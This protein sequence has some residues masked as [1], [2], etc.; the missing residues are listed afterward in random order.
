MGFPLL[1][2]LLFYLFRYTAPPP[3]RAFT[4]QS[5][6]LRLKPAPATIILHLLN[7]IVTPIHHIRT[8]AMVYGSCLYKMNILL[9]DRL[10]SDGLRR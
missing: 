9:A 6:H 2:L 7:I 1:C 8:P 10:W 3:A 4:R 5:K